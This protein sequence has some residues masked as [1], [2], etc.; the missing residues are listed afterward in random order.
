MIYDYTEHNI[1]PIK[2]G[3]LSEWTV[4]ID[5]VFEGDRV[6]DITFQARNTLGTELISKKLSTGGITFI[7]DEQL[8]M[9]VFSVAFNPADTIGKSGV[10]KYELD[11]KDKQ[12]RPFATFGGKFTILKEVNTL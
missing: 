8:S 11:I 4:E 3:N 10:H 1:E 9:W 12:G 2:E 6:G 7:Y 5:Q